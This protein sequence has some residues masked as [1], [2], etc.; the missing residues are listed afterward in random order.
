MLAAVFA[1]VLQQVA[2][3]QGVWQ[4][5][6]PA[7]PLAPPASATATPALPASARADPYGYERA[8]CSPLI[9]Q[10]SESLEACQARVRAA[11]AADLGDDM[12]TGLSGGAALE[13]CRQQA[14]G[15]RY[16]L[17]CGAPSRSVPTGPALRERAC[18]TR[19]NVTG[20]GTVSFQEDCTVGGEAA[21]DDGLKIRIGGRD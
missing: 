20:Q 19:P 9:R 15:D 21:R 1:L 10:A 16:A 4:T 17:Q 3:G 5:P 8:E 13:E 7:A 2:A 14:A 6:A 18:T 12:P 11:L